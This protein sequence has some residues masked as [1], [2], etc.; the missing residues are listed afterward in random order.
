[1]MMMYVMAAIRPSCM[2]RSRPSHTGMHPTTKCR[3]QSF[4]RHFRALSLTGAGAINGCDGRM[5]WTDAMDGHG[6]RMHG[7]HP[8]SFDWLGSIEPLKGTPLSPHSSA[9]LSFF[10]ESVLFCFSL[11]RSV[12]LAFDCQVLCKTSASRSV[13]LRFTIAGA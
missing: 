11:C 10:V 12:L 9:L 1:M 2:H 7:C 4:F 5:R 8:V 6:G 13:C 3:R